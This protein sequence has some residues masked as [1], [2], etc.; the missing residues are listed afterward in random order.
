MENIQDVFK[1]INVKTWNCT[2]GERYFDPIRNIFVPITPEETVRQRMLV[3]MQTVM[4]IPMSNICVEA[5]LKH[6]GVTSS[7]GRMDIVVQFYNLKKEIKV[8]C[9]IECKEEKVYIEGMQVYNQAENYSKLVNADYFG[10]VNGKN[11]QFYH[12]I[13]SN[14]FKPIQGVPSFE[15]MKKGVFSELPKPQPFKRLKYDTYFNVDFLQNEPW[16]QTII[17]EDTDIRLMPFIVAL[18]DC[19]LDSR[20]K[21]NDIDNL[22]FSIIKDLG[23][24]FRQYNDMSDGGFGTGDY[25]VFLIMDDLKKQQ[26]LCGFMI[27]TT[28]KLSNDKKYGNQTGKS[29]LVC[30]L[31]NGN[32]DETVVQINLNTFL[33]QETGMLFSITH[34]G[35]IVRKGAKKADFLS[36]IKQRNQSL[37]VQNQI[38]LGTVDFSYP[39]YFDNSDVKNLFS[40]LIEYCVYRDEYKSSLKKSK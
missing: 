22:R 10:I 37:I 25:R 32:V 39:I 15:D 17:G 28:A 9:V 12:K 38:K 23:V 1:S 7:R 13:D 11:I 21:L 34:N 26:F 31:N 8:L 36:Y 40:N 14:L 33:C 3:Y 27:T 24:H 5:H 2:K 16:I 18:D 19:L 6:Y 20:R 29:V 4:S 35:T 30:M